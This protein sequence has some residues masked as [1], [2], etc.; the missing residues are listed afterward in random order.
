MRILFLSNYFPPYTRGGYELWCQ[1]VAAELAGRGHQLAVLTTRP[2]RDKA[3][4][5]GDN[6]LSQSAVTVHRCLH[7]EVE[8]GLGHTVIRLL[9]DR[10]RLEN[11]NLKA[12]QQITAAFQ[13][14]VAVAWGLWN[15]ARAVPALLEELL[16]GRMAY[17]LCDYW[18][19]YPTAYV[20]RWQEPSR[21]KAMQLPKEWLG[22]LFLRRL[23]RQP[24]ASLRLE[25]P[26]CVSRAVRRLLVEAGVPVAHA[27]VIY[28]GTKTAPHLPTLVPATGD[29]RL[30]LLYLGRLEEEKGVH[31]ALQAVAQVAHQGV[32]ISLDVYGRGKPDYE[33]R[34]RQLVN[35]ENLQDV[36]S[37]CGVVD[38]GRVP[39]LMTRYD[40]LVFP[41]EWPEPFARTVLEA[42]AAGLPVVG[43]V[44]GG[45]GEILIEGL[46]GFTFSPGDARGL[47]SR[48]RCLSEDRPLLQK[49]GAAGRQSVLENFTFARMVDE[50]EAVLKQI[51]GNGYYA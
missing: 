9:K 8:A 23:E 35:D 49:V 5:Q 1:E 21:R 15:V 17:Y 43:T 16:P 50:F 19:S 12:L 51:N 2:P 32:K 38:N 39:Q 27:R 37:F 7:P 41:S 30:R 46:T 24:T 26:I 36:V 4:C 29:E 22:R 44:M 48:L 28:G 34:L 11:E 18:L 25:H 10:R 40:T 13:P 31:T 20:Q 45:T 6:G 14:E 33:A 3:S 42:M 47:A